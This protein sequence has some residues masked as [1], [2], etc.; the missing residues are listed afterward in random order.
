MSS[1]AAKLGIANH[2]AIA[3]ANEVNVANINSLQDVLNSLGGYIATHAATVQQGSGETVATAIN[4]Q[5]VH[6]LET[7]RPPAQ[8]AQLAHILGLAP[9]P[10][11][12]AGP[13]DCMLRI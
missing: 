2:E 8:H 3:A 13:A 6:T 4:A 7:G 9:F 10:A 12:R 11:P 5:P 1:A